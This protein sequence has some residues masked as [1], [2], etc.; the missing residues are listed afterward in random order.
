MSGPD[1][2]SAAVLAVLIADQADSLVSRRVG[3]VE[4]SL[5][6]FNGDKHAGFTR[7]ADGRTPNYPRGTRIRNDRQVSLVSYEELQ[8]VA[9]RLEVEEIQPEWLGANL[10]VGGIPGLST[11]PHNTRLRF[12]GG[13]VLVVQAE[14]MP[15]AGP[16]RVLAAQFARPELE[17]NFPRTALHLRGLVAVVE[18]GGNLSPGERLA[19][20]RP[21]DALREG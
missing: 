21:R 7:R 20:S 11:L 1:T 12:S 3:E 18:R 16:G 2:T 19:V 5:E 6:G 17:R 4:V 9:E 10:L 13:V 14:N 15:C 8:L